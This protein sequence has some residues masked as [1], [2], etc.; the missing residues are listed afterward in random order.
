MNYHKLFKV[1]EYIENNSMCSIKDIQ[2]HTNMGKSHIYNI[3]DFSFN[4]ALIHIRVNMNTKK[5]M[6]LDKG[7]QVLNLLYEL[8]QLINEEE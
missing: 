5:F 2:K 1:L 8:N 4:N 6:L 7:K 3:I